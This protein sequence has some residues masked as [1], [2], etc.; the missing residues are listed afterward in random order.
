MSVLDR[1]TTEVA[2]HIPPM[3]GKS[4]FTTHVRAELDQRL[5]ERAGAA[6]RPPDEAM[7]LELLGELGAPA[8]FA[9][10]RNPHPYLVGPRLFPVFV[11]V[12]QIV[13]VVLV[14]VLAVVSGI[15]IALSS[16]MTALEVLGA[17]GDAVAGIVSAALGAFGALVLTFAILERF[18][19]AGQLEPGEKEPWDPASL[20]R[21]PAADTVKPWEP[22]V[23]IVFLL[24]AIILFN[25]ASDLIAFYVHDGEDWTATPILTDAFFRWLPLMNIGWVAGIVLNIVL[26][27]TG[28]W[29]PATRVASIAISILQLVILVLLITG[30]DIIALTPELLTG[31]GVTDPGVAETVVIWV[32]RAIR[33]ALAFGLLG[34]TVEIIQGFVRLVRLLGPAQR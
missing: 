5:A 22:V 21:P 8:E 32:E 15:S 18:A 28:R 13:L 9:A 26:L 11:L 33:I 10:V 29:T 30:P 31:G 1:Y 24:L 19:R 16:P 4:D 27:R 6:G 7:E 12:A 17:V 25:A 34:T 23:A 20:L 14:T 2:R 3:R